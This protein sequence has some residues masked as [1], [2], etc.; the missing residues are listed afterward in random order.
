[1][2]FSVSSTS[3]LGIKQMPKDPST[4]AE[5]LALQ[6]AKGLFRLPKPKPKGFADFCS[7]DFLG[8]G[9]QSLVL[10]NGLSAGATGS[11][12]VSGLHAGLEELEKWAATFWGAE[13]AVFFPTGFQANLGVIQAVATRHDVI[14]MDERIHASLRDAARGT[15]AQTHFFA[16]NSVTD[17]EAWLQRAQAKRKAEGEIYVVTEGVFSMAGTRAPLA[18][19][20]AIC[21]RFQA[22]LIVD[23][24]H[25]VGLY[26]KAGRGC[27]DEVGLTERVPVRIFPLGKAA[28]VQ[29]GLVVGSSALGQMLENFSR[30]LIYSTAPSPLLTWLVLDRLQAMGNAE[31]ERTNLKQV[32]KRMNQVLVNR[33]FGAVVPVFTLDEKA[34]PAML[35]TAVQAKLWVKPIRYPTVPKGEECLRITLHANQTD[36]ELHRLG[37][38]IRAFDLQPLRVQEG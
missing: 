31:E 19:M 6:Q 11:R 33:P 17:L 9:Q 15:L 21:N 26:G 30:P 2:S 1:M 35:D 23:E 4:W 7:N 12:H 34:W 36:D 8:L 29:G 24:A 22:V 10:P 3:A 13:R 28:G 16:H 18:E 20:V 38:W 37:E 14:L 5:R 27:V 25:S 32:E